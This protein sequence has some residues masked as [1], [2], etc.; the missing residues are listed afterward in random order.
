MALT[1]IQA[2][3]VRIA[4]KPRITREVAQALG[5]SLYFKLGHEPITAS[6]APEVRKNDII[7]VENTGYVVDYSNAIITLA[8]LPVVN[9]EFEFIYYWSIFT[10]D[11]IQYFLDDSAGS[12]NIAASKALLAI[13]A[14]A[15][16]IAQ[17]TSMAGGGGLGAVSLDTSVAARELRALA[18]LLVTQEQDIANNTPYDQL[19]EVVWNDQSLIDGLDQHLIRES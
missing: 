17:R 15:A 19:T 18:T 3:R 8:S 12:T 9:D 14:D 6:P 10:D 13:A 5:D 7:L 4:D 2:V 1:D 11:E 16:K